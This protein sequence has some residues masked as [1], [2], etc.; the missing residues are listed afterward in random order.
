MIILYTDGAANEPAG[1]KPCNYANNEANTA[2][3]AGI[4]VYTIG[5]GLEVEL[6]AESG[7]PYNGVRAT[8]LLADMATNS[9]DDHGGCTGTGGA[10][11][12]NADGDHFLCQPTSGDL[13]VVFKQVAVQIVTGGS[14]LISLP[15]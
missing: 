11:L 2:K 12:E 10:A 5:Y 1:S 3:T 6:C 7:S 14:F 4:E 8:R 15:E 9:K 13:S